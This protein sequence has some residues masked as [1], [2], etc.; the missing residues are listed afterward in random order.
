MSLYP[1]LFACTPE[2][3]AQFAPDPRNAAPPWRESMGVGVAERRGF[4]GGRIF[5]GSKRNVRVHRPLPGPAPT[6]PA[7]RPPCG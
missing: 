2:A 5:G 6:S 4:F 3:L 1:T 7:R